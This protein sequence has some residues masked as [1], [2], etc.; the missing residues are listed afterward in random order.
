[1]YFFYLWNVD[2]RLCLSFLIRM[3]MYDI[4]CIVYILYIDLLSIK[5]IWL[6]FKLVGYVSC[7]LN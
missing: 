7:C 5:F 4:Y 1:M 2:L 6:S 3:I